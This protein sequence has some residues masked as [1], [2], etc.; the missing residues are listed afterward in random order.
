MY[1]QGKKIGGDNLM[2]C[3]AKIDFCI[4][5]SYPISLPLTKAQNVMQ[6]HF[7][8]KM[9]CKNLF[10]QRCKNV[11]LQSKAKM[12]KC[13]GLWLH[14]AMQNVS[15]PGFAWSLRFLLPKARVASGHRPL[16][17]KNTFSYPIS[18]PLTKAQNVMQKFIFA[19]MQKFIFAKM[20]WHFA[21]KMWC[22]NLFLQRCKNVFLQSKAKQAIDFLC[23]NIFL[24]FA[25][26][27]WGR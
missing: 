5:F 3:F 8:S 23:A 10:L 2:L 24:L 26:F 27:Y 9:W 12:Q 20:Q 14:F 19:K 17:C 7:A 21:C 16:L 11:F 1:V 4:T 25:R 15:P 22:K 6:L 13:D 18:L